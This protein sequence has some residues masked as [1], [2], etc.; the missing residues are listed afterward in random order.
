MA[1]KS[2]FRINFRIKSSENLSD[3][4]NRLADIISRK[5]KKEVQIFMKERRNGH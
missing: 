4:L 5:S 1:S 3:E 2:D